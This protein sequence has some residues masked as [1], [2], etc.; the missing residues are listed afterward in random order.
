V[1][2]QVQQGK[3]FLRHFEL[4][5]G[6]QQQQQVLTQH[7]MYLDQRT[8]AGGIINTLMKNKKTMHSPANMPNARIGINSEIAVAKNAEAVV[9]DVTNTA[10]DARCAVYASLSF[11]LD[12]TPRRF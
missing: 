11:K 1:W 6:E 7:G 5:I 10:L 4:H 8:S 3:H 9:N 12:P 2:Q